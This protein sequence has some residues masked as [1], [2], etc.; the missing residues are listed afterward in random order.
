MSGIFF[1][2]LEEC[3]QQIEEI[4]ER[5]ASLEDE[6]SD[7]RLENVRMSTDFATE[8]AQLQLRAVQLQTRVN[9]VSYQDVR[10]KKILFGVIREGAPASQ[11]EEDR[12]LGSGR[13]SRLSGVKTRMELTWQKEREETGRLLQDA[14]AANKEIR[15]TLLEV[16]C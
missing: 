3:Y 12:I 13:T 16:C 6:L 9:E 4:Q 11:L 5:V 8:K 1:R 10:K 15:T 7:A 2:Q 14:Y